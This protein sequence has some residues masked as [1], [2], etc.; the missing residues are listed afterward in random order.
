V[1]GQTLQPHETVVTV[2]T[3]C[4][5]TNRG[6]M[7]LERSPS[8]VGTRDLPVAGCQDKFT[9]WAQQ[10]EHDA[11]SRLL[12]A[13]QLRAAGRLRLNA[14][15]R[16]LD[17]GC[18]TGAAV[19]GASATVSLAAGID[20]SAAMVHRA[21]VC[22]RALPNAVFLLADAERLPFPA[23]TFTAVLSTAT[24]R[25]FS[26]PVGAVRE[27]ARVARPGGRIVVADFLPCG[28]SRRRRSWNGLGRPERE[29]RWVDP[30]Q[31][32]SAAPVGVTEVVRYSTAFGYYAIV[33]AAKPDSPAVNGRRRSRP[34]RSAGRVAG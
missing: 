16:F 29:A 3:P 6:L 21:R 2:V 15:D 13:L 22:A 26:D 24:L 17:V 27:M 14:A 28:A 12:T 33:S 25:H 23:A 20:R 7:D 4:E 1:L 32:V 31:A 9:G 10:Y 18:A 8:P 5:L 34:G 30:L 19:R 11:L